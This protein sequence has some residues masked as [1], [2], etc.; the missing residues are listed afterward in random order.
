M[1]VVIRD[2]WVECCGHL[3]AFD[4]ILKLTN[5]S[6]GWILCHYMK[7]PFRDLKKE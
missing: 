3:S 1:E 5:Q 7:S 6:N 4:I 2:I